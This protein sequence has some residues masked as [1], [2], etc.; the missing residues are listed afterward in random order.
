MPSVGRR[1]GALTNSKLV[2]AEALGT[3]GQA[4]LMQEAQATAS[5]NHPN[6][7]AVYDVGLAAEDDESVDAAFIVMELIDGRPLSQ[8]QVA[9]L[10]EALIIGRQ[11]ATALESA[12]GRG[13]IHRRG[14]ICR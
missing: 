4:R 14:L 3:E 5:L 7:V 12:H 6:I 9:G 8:Y 2:S 13:I 10:V 1:T 11:I